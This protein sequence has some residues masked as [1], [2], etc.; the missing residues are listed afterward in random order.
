MKKLLILLLVAVSYTLLG[1]NYPPTPINGLVNPVTTGLIINPSLGNS[2]TVILNSGDY[3]P[4]VPNTLP[5]GTHLIGIGRPRIHWDSFII[6]N[7]NATTNEACIGIGGDNITIE[8]IDFVQ[9]NLTGFPINL[10]GQ[11]SYSGAA[12]FTNL[13][14][15][16][17]QFLGK[18]DIFYFGSSNYMQG[19]V[20]ECYLESQWDMF[21]MTFGSVTNDWKFVNNQYVWLDSTIAGDHSAYKNCWS[22]GT[23]FKGTNIWLNCTFEDRAASS[24]AAYQS[25]IFPPGTMDGAYEFRNCRFNNGQQLFGA[26]GVAN[27]VFYTGCSI[28]PTMIA[29]FDFPPQIMAIE[30]QITTQTVNYTA[31]PGD[32]IILLNGNLTMTLPT[33]VGIKGKQYTIMCKT[34]GTNG[35]LTTGGQTLFGFPNTAATKWT[36]SAV[37]HNTTVKSDGANWIVIKTDN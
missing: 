24:D 32:S 26:Q 16:N 12:G 3:Y 17:C 13:L 23:S 20:R 28:T 34:A 21:A 6:H 10:I 11:A 7:G 29:A 31:N 25:W 19:V 22:A 14:V 37:G 33:A 36:N 27:R 35:I 9:T 18:N 1:A 15:K 2:N 4:S 30:D 8:G 5:I